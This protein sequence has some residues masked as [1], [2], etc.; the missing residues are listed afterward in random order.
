MKFNL[1]LK[2]EKTVVIPCFLKGKEIEFFKS[3]I[4]KNILSLVME[5]LDKFYFKCENGST[6]FLDVKDYKILL[7]GVNEKFV[8]EDL[9]KSY[10]S[11]FKF[12]K[13]NKESKVSVVF[14]NSENL[15]NIKAVVEG[16]D[17]SNYKFDRYLSEKN[18]FKIKYSFV[19]DKKFSKNIKEVNIVNREVKFVRDLVNMNASE[20]TPE[21]FEEL[22]REFSKSKKLKIE[23]LDSKTIS[24]K[25]LGLLEAVGQGSN[26]PSRL[27]LIEY[28]GKPKSPE[29]I[30]LVGKGITFDTGGVNL[31]PTNGILEMKLDMGGAGTVF[32]A[33]KSC[34]KLGVKKNLIVVLSCAENAIS[35][36]AY[37]PGDVIKSY[38]GKSV[39]IKN[40]DAEGRL[41][42]GDAISYVQK[43]YNVTNIIDVATLTGACLVALGPSLI[44]SLGNNKNMIDGLFKSGEKVYERVWNLPIYDEHRD[45]L[46][47]KIADFTNLGG[48]YGGSI[49]AAAFIEKFVGERI[50]WV[51]LDIAGAAYSTKEDGYVPEF[52]TGRGVRLLVDYLKNN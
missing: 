30:A 39:E 29:K 36:S 12:L 47:S 10:S 46:K 5:K 24:K 17:L 45:L 1:S 37:L 44:A 21:K 2:L 4:D 26:K 9:R 41:V 20:M 14:P 32:G 13:E 18:D 49:S 27:I 31:K 50:S 15:E 8:L 16:L 23:V 6:I 42:L 22:G 11:V 38:C 43:N 28:K 34:V 51:H 33:F 48:S 3:S 35:G 40:T 7:V 19:L 52:G 25:G